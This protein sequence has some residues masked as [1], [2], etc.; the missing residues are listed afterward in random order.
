MA[1]IKDKKQKQTGGGDFYRTARKR[2]SP[3]FAAHV[4]HAVKSGQ[5]LY[6]NAYKL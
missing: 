1:S 6:K 5:L 3:T 2:I 4:D